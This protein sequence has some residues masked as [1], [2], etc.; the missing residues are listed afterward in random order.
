MCR[1]VWCGAQP[2]QRAIRRKRS[3]GGSV[4]SAGRSLRRHRQGAQ[5]V[6]A[7]PQS[8]VNTS[9][10]H[11][12]DAVF[13]PTVSTPAA[14]T[15]AVSGCDAWCM[16][17]SSRIEQHNTTATLQHYIFQSGLQ[18]V[19]DS[20]RASDELV[21]LQGQGRIADA[22][23]LRS[24]PRGSSPSPSPLPPLPPQV[25]FCTAGFYP[26]WSSVFS[27]AAVCHIRN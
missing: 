25:A 24:A 10:H 11:S 8:T 16:G 14:L 9:I 7:V 27:S 2:T 13:S 3:S 4:R 12:H 15:L 5:H 22:E 26:H 19:L 6:F 17:V 18:P 20:R 23:Q 21:Q 1:P